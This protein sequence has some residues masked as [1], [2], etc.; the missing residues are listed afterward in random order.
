MPKTSSIYQF[1]VTLK[2]IKPKIWRQIQ[3]P[4]NYTFQDLH[5]TIQNA[6]GW[7]N[8]HLYQ[9]EMATH[10]HHRM[11]IGI[12]ECDQLDYEAT[13]E[14][15]FLSPKDKALYLYDFGD[16]WKHEVILEKILPRVKNT[17]YPQCIKG[18][19]ACPPEDC[20]GVWGYEDILEIIKNPNHEKYAEHMEWLGEKFDPEEFNPKSIVFHNVE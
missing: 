1:K 5:L 16:S 12:N 6:M 10:R 15:Y 8:D 19:G 9:F 11:V 2:F 14:Q 7:E 20:G 18:K 3:V 4:A 17:K 13:I